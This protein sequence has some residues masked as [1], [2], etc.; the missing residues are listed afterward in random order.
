MAGWIS[1]IIVLSDRLK[2]LEGGTFLSR[3]SP[4][5]YLYTYPLITLSELDQLQ[6]VHSGPG[7]PVQ[8]INNNN[9]NN[10]N[11]RGFME[12][13]QQECKTISEIMVGDWHQLKKL[14]EEK[15]P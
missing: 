14:E 2:S 12:F 1:L 3:P 6:V 7:P 15:E 5:T 8:T 9:N 10:N 4:P 13:G 11:N